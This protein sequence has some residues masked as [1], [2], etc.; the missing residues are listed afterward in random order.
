MPLLLAHLIGDYCLQSPWM[1]HNKSRRS[2]PCLVHVL[3]Y[4]ACFLFLTRS[5]KAL[6]VI[7]GTHFV[8]DRFGVAR[9]LVWL[10]NHLGPRL[11]YSPWCYCRRS[12]YYAPE[13]DTCGLVQLEAACTGA[14]AQPI[15][16]SVWL[17]IA[18]DNTLHLL[19]N[20]LAV[21]HL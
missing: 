10:K 19:I 9:Y 18:A 11:Y 13:E 7:G 5:W 21:F 14:S 16:L 12:G 15:W 3:L 8:I 4:T 2:F 6:L 20:Y 1:A 17:T